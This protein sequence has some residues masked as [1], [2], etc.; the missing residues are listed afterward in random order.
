MTKRADAYV[1]AAIRGACEDV[2]NAGEGERNA[3]LNKAA[4]SLGRLVG[5]GVLDSET[6]HAYLAESASAAGLSRREAEYTI[7]RALADGQRSPNNSAIEAPNAR[8]RGRRRNRRRKAPSSPVSMPMKAVHARPPERAS[9]AVSTLLEAVW[10]EIRD[11]PLT[12]EA[13]AWCYRHGIDPAV[14]HDLGVRDW[15]SGRAELARALK[16]FDAQTKVDAGFYSD[17]GK[18]WFPF[19]GVC[20]GDQS[21]RGLAIPCWMPDEPAPRSYRWRFY[22]AP[23]RVPKSVAMYGRQTAPIV[24]LKPADTLWLEPA[25]RT[26]HVFIVEGEKDALALLTAAQPSAGVVGLL[27]ASACARGADDWQHAPLDWLTWLTRAAVID[28]CVH[29]DGCTGDGHTEGCSGVRIATTVARWAKHVGLKAR[30]RKRLVRGGHDL[31]DM[32]TGSSPY[33]R[34]SELVK[35]MRVSLQGPAR[36][37]PRGTP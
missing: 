26:P 7:R 13:I 24:G 16:G 2:R 11:Q 22:D 31:A 35:W 37:G 17:S 6:A 20:R 32:S 23:E 8:A 30:V 15:S 27:S 5:A 18:P 33:D 9:A 19:A 21:M 34:N 28:V 10:S 29:C 4:F 14:A 1:E 36:I 25:T 3:T 12:T